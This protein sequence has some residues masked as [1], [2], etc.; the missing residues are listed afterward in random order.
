[1][2]DDSNPGLSLDPAA[3]EFA[4]RRAQ[5]RQELDAI[6]PAMQGKA[7]ADP[8]RRD[9][10]EAVY[11]RAANDPA[12]V[13][14]ANLVPHPLTK[15]WVGLQTRGVAGMRVLDVGCGLGDNAEC[16]A[17]AGAIVTAFDLVPTAVAWARRRFP[18]TTVAYCAGDL[19][20]PPQA[21]W[22]AFDLVHECY[23]L[24]ALTV[25]I[26]PKALA[27][28]RSLLAPGGRL[29]LVARARDEDSQ[30]SGPPW[31][32]PPS[33]FDEAERQGLT[34]MAIEDISAAAGITRRHW[35]ALLVRSED[36]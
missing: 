1:M 19:L 2:P 15:S 12:R 3:P 36:R 33:I 18:E 5:A 31:P 34:P 27:A 8:L 30:E 25:E 29:L 11:A 32:L 22:Q 24:Q 28:L 10:F 17:R 20:A 9:W 7:N 6:D 23:T 14:W 16:F 13:P 35:R 4:A 26:L 21:W